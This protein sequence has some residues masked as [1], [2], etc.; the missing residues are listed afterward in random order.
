MGV[1]SL[2]RFFEDCRSLKF[3]KFHLIQH[4]LCPDVRAFAAEGHTFSGRPW[5]SRTKMLPGGGKNN[6]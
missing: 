3:W 4:H 5:L 1:A 6:V 2:K